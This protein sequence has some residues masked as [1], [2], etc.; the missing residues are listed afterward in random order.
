LEDIEQVILFSIANYFLKF[1]EAY[2]R[3]NG[4]LDNDWYEYVEYGTTN[5]LSI[6]LQKCGFSRETSDYIRNHQYEYVVYQPNGKPLLKRRLANCGRV[7]VEKEVS[8]VL[9]NIKELFEE[10][11]GEI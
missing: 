8:D 11:G 10:P 4:D 1:S 3:I 2:K 5:P 6:M 9:L 7:T